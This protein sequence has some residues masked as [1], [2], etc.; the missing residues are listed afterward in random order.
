MLLWSNFTFGQTG[1]NYA[2]VDLHD[3]YPGNFSDLKANDSLKIRFWVSGHY[4]NGLFVELRLTNKNNW[5]YNR[6]FVNY[7]TDSVQIHSLS[8]EPAFNQLWNNLISYGILDL[9]DQK[10]APIIA[11]KNDKQWN[12]ADS[13]KQ[14]IIDFYNGEYITIEIFRSDSYK[15]YSYYSPSEVYKM[16]FE[17]NFICQEHKQMNNIVWTFH[18]YFNMQELARIQLQEKIKKNDR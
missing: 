7:N 9:P 17:N 12:L 3:K 16:C 1:T 18:Q 13:T 5:T 6:G 4:I 15:S 14:R 10:G 11:V 2:M 8:T